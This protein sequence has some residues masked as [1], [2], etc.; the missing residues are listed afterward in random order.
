MA[1]R[2]LEPIIQNFKQIWNLFFVTTPKILSLGLPLRGSVQGT[3]SRILNEIFLNLCHSFNFWYNL[4]YFNTFDW[5]LK[6]SLNTRR[7]AYNPCCGFACSCF[8]QKTCFLHVLNVR[9]S[10]NALIWCFF[11]YFISFFFLS[12]HCINSETYS[13]YNKKQSSYFHQTLKKFVSN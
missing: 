11:T 5:L 4:V 7:K 12:V 1:P 13:V 2:N 6:K 9:N 8:L 3:T 10:E